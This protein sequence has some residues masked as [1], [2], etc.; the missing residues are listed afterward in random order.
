MRDRITVGLSFLVGNAAQ[1]TAAKLPD[2]A[3]QQDSTGAT[4]A[5]SLMRR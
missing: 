3:K 5:T 1:N 4:Q 2:T